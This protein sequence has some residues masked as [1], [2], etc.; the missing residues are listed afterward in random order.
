MVAATAATW[1]RA[2]CRRAAA[3]GVWADTQ[4]DRSQALLLLLLLLGLLG[5]QGRLALLQGPCPLQHTHWH[6]A[7]GLHGGSCGAGGER[8]GA[9][10]LW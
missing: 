1:G 9:R 5:M 3:G 2:G 6:G 8:C 10:A 4:P 7:R